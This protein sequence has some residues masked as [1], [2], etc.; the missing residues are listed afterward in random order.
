MTRLNEYDQPIGTPVPIW[1]ARPLPPHKAIEGRIFRLK[2]I[3][4]KSHGVEL[5]AALTGAPDNRP[6]TYLFTEP[7]ANQHD[8]M[9]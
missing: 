8:C 2:P 4:A 6:W 9:V 7:I 1:G 5:Y 3:N